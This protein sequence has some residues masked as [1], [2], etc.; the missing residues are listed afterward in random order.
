MRDLFHR[1][2]NRIKNHPNHW[3]RKSIGICLVTGGVLGSVLPVLGLWM[4][5]LDMVLLAVDI[6]WFRRINR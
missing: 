5:P 1:R 2:F 6:P 4:L 3:V